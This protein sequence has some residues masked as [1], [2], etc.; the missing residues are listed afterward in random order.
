MVNVKTRGEAEPASNA[1]RAAMRRKRWTI[2]YL[3]AEAGYSITHV[4]VALREPR[5]ASRP[6]ARRLSEVLGLDP[7]TLAPKGGQP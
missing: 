7:E 3:A 6:L 2:A 5:I 4:S 1:W